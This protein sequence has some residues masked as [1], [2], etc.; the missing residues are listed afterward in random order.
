MYA[1]F[2]PTQ[3]VY[4]LVLLEGQTYPSQTTTDKIGSAIEG[5]GVLPHA[6]ALQ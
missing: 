4:I 2:S 3:C 1:S 5:S 6:E